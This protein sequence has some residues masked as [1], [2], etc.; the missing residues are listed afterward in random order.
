MRVDYV[1]EGFMHQDM[2]YLKGNFSRKDAKIAKAQRRARAF[3]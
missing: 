1:N 3:G 2:L